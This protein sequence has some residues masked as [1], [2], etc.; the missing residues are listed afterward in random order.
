MESRKEIVKDLLSEFEDVFSESD[1]VA[2]MALKGFLIKAV[3]KAFD[4]G[5]SKSTLDDNSKAVT[6]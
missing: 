5:V 6:E 3:Y 4:N 1:F 2:N